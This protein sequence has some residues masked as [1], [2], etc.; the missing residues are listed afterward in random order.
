[1]EIVW[2]GHSCF[3]I[4]GKET[5]LVFDPCP[6]ECGCVSRW[7]NPQA[8]LVSHLHPG[9]SFTGELAGA[10]RVFSGA[11]EYE[12]G[13]AFISGVGSYHDSEQGA[14]RGKNTIY[15]VEM[16]GLTLCHVGD[17]G[18]PLTGQTLRDI[19]KVDVLF[20][21]VGD[22]TTLSV[23]EARALVRALQPRYVLPMHYRTET[24][25]PDLE[26]LETFLTAMAV[27]Q[28]ETRPR[29]SVTSNNLPLNMQIVVLTC[30]SRAG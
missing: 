25:R 5:T 13:G 4:R 16:E 28:P 7:G 11:G 9:H 22:V 23:A 15:L 29:L 19:G 18:H 12:V 20:V 6:P 27:P 14:E 1:M 8:V 30:D 2:S 26:P 24:A 10:S 21:P 17:L 3:T